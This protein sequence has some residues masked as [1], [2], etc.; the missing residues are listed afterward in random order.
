MSASKKHDFSLKSHITKVGLVVALSLNATA[1]FAANECRIK[2]QHKRDNG[3]AYSPKFLYINSGQ[4][5]AVNARHLDYVKNLKNRDVKIWVGNYSKVLKKNDVDPFPGFHLA[6]VKFKKVKCLGSN[7][8]TPIDVIIQQMKN[9]G[10]SANQIAIHLKNTLNQSASQVVSWLKSIGFSGYNTISKALKAAGYSINQVVSAMKSA[11]EFTAKQIAKGLKSAGYTLNQIV[12]ALKAAGKFSANAIAK[13]L[14]A[15]GYS[16]NQIVSALKAAGKFSANAIAK[17]LKAAGYSVNQIV[18]ALKAAGKFS[19]NAI[20]KALKVAGYSVNQI[21]SALKAAGKFSA[22]AIAKALKAAGYSV[23]Q[24][25]SALKAAGGYA[26]N[27][28]TKAL[29]SAGYTLSQI[30]SALKSAGKYTANQIAKAL[31]YA[32]YSA[33]QIAK[34]LHDEL[35]LS[36]QKV[37]NILKQIGYSAAQAA[38]AVKSFAQ[39]TARA[40]GKMPGAIASALTFVD[41]LKGLRTIHLDERTPRVN[42]SILLRGNNLG[43]IKRVVGLPVSSSSVKFGKPERY[44]GTERLANTGYQIGNTYETMKVS[45]SFVQ[46]SGKWR[47]PLNGKAVFYDKTN[48]AVKGGTYHWA[49]KIIPKPPKPKVDP[50]L[51]ARLDAPT[52]ISPNNQEVRYNNASNLKSPAL[53]WN[54]SRNANGYVVSYTKNRSGAKEFHNV[55]NSRANTLCHI[56]TKLDKGNYIWRVRAMYKPA[57]RYNGSRPVYSDYTTYRNFRLIQDSDGNVSPTPRCN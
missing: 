1:G 17:A 56:I 43:N 26:G 40:A 50:N 13:A 30:V 22:N 4:T 8:A 41:N 54:A 32:G 37:E 57:A 44:F 25:V 2:Y 49:L 15:A 27:Q 53:K 46:T 7:Q 34:A 48:K 6:D 3:T 18:S 10:Q 14:K 42:F 38:N 23:N 9:A 47:Y 31:K 51:P 52:F 55:I 35:K 28:V 39:N 12:S 45:F 33:Q 5:K 29:K 11:G 21:V 19:A 36:A 16:V 20:A 24:I